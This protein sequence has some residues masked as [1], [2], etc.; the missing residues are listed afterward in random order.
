M[1]IRD[2]CGSAVP[3]WNGGVHCWRSGVGCP[4]NIGSTGACAFR[5]DIG[6]HCC[7]RWS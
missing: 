6:A 3:F 5:S 7:H 1:S 2:Y 4:W